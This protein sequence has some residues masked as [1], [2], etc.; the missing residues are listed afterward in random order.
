MHCYIVL[1][2]TACYSGSGRHSERP[3]F[4]RA[5]IPIGGRAAIPKGRHSDLAFTCTGFIHTVTGEVSRTVTNMFPH[6]YRH[7]PLP[8]K[9]AQSLAKNTHRYHLLP[10]PLP[11]E[12]MHCYP[13]CLHCYRQT[14]R[15][16]TVPRPHR[17]R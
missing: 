7:A 4:R 10:A 12:N 17:Y 9:T 16:V 8:A 6:R 2:A 3:P 5:A 15:T 14:T 13:I 1:M 11:A